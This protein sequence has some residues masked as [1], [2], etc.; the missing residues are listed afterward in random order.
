VPIN[1]PLAQSNVISWHGLERLREFADFSWCTGS[2]YILRRE[3]LL[4]IGGFPT[5]GLTEDVHSSINM[6]AKGWKTAY[7]PEALQY[8]LIPDSYYAHLK[9]FVRWVSLPNV[10]AYH[11]SLIR[12]IRVLV[13]VSSVLLSVSTWTEIR[14]VSLL[15]GNE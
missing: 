5:S 3:A 6:M 11:L 10:A 9:Q 14:L 7:V 15:Q 13:D 8:G 1:D 4:D 12:G 2:G